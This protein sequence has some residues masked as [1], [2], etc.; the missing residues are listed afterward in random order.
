MAHGQ[1]HAREVVVGIGDGEPTDRKGSIFRD[2]LG[3]GQDI[4]RCIV[5]HRNRNGVRI[6]RSI[7]V[8]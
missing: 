3:A 4:G 5:R 7:P 8:G 2:G 1:L 6:R